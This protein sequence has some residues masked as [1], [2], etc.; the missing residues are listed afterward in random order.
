MTDTVIFQRIY[1]VEDFEAF[2]AQPENAE[3]RFELIQGEIVEKLPTEEHALIAAMIS[4]LLMS[5]IL[6]NKLGRVG[7][8][9]RHH[10]EGDFHNTRLPDVAFTGVERAQ[11]VVRKG[12]VPGMPDLAVEI[13]SPGDRPREMRE[14]ADYYLRNGARLVW[15]VYPDSRSIEVCTRNQS[16]KLELQSLDAE[17]M[18]DGGEVIPGFMVQVGRFFEI[19]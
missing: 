11:P 9:P 8:E 19:E 14:K 12:S 6:P 1:N 17:K 16:D 15:L 7:V 2:I 3:R 5:H 4:H 18:L 13:Q 10:V